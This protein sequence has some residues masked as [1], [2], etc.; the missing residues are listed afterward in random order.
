MLYKIEGKGL[1]IKVD[2]EELERLRDQRAADPPAF[3]MDCFMYDL[4]EDLIANSD[5]EWIDP[6][7]ALRLCGDLTD[8]PTLGIW[9][10][11]CG[12][13]DCP[14]CATL[15]RWAFM[16]YQVCSVQGRLAAAGV[17]TFQGT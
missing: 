3:V 13:C 12:D 15:T 17:A 1:V 10:N 2:A 5:L 14:G 11:E 16:D 8:A 7:T 9:A 6:E 4:F